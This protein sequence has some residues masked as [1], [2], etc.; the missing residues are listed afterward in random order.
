[1][2]STRFA[3]VDS[4]HAHAAFVERF[5]QLGVTK[6]C[7]DGTVFCADAAV[8]RAQMAVFLPRAF[9]LPEG[10]DPGFGDVSVGAWYVS[11]VSALA[12]SGVTKG[13]MDGTVFCPDG[14]TTRAQM[15]TSCTGRANSGPPTL[16]SPGPVCSPL[17]LPAGSIRAGSE[18][19]GRSNAGTLTTPC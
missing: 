18:S 15:A 5:A 11:A 2:A 7:M 6:G 16:P 12:A 14:T 3:D 8:T 4:S 13:C 17:F 19:T 1:M 10:P 9:G